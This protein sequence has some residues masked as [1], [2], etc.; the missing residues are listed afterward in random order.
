VPRLAIVIS[1][2]G[3]IESLERTLVSVLENRPTD[4]EIFVALNRP[5]ADPYDLRGEVRFVQ[6]APQA[7]SIEC[8]NQALAAS[9]A[10]FVHL[11][12]SGCQATEGWTEQ[13]LARFGDRQVGSVAPWIMD[14]TRP[15]RI[16]AAGIGYTPGGRRI[17][18][19][20]G[21]AELTPDAQ[22]ALVG[23]CGAA[24]FY[25]RAALETVGGLN[26]QLGIQQADVDVAIALKRAGFT[27]AVAPQ[28]K[29]LACEQIGHLEAP[30]EKAIHDERLF[31]RNLP[32]RGRLKA[33]AAHAGVVTLDLLRS[34]PRLQLFSQL[35][36]RS[37]ALCQMSSHVR[38]RRALAELG[39]RATRSRLAQDH[40]R[41]DR[42][43]DGPMLADPGKPRVHSS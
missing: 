6:A 22:A 33:L 17:L 20:R 4:C 37:W 11:L 8:V 10:P 7:T 36:G 15:D 43:H 13:P 41:L 29:L 25:R 5:Y 42:S 35:A 39:Q 32:E 34:A 12:A 2:V 28:S 24:A 31:W 14:A 16:Y 21:Y 23:A 40:L 3:S 30:L 27:L 26:S 9:R 19:G 38:H 18:L 1:A